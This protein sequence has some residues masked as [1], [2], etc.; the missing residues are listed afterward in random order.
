M[1]AFGGNDNL[2][3]REERLFA[4][5]VKSNKKHGYFKEESLSKAIEMRKEQIMNAYH[6]NIPQT[7]KEKVKRYLMG[8][9]IYFS[10][11]QY[12]YRAGKCFFH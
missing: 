3:R 12:V 11:V 2:L 7:R 9:P 6:Q 8:Y 5:M 4:S 10:A 1:T